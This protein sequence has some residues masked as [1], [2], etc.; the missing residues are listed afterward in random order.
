[1]LNVLQILFWHILMSDHHLYPQF[2]QCIV[3]PI[4]LLANPNKPVLTKRF[5]PDIFSMLVLP[6]VGHLRIT[7]RSQ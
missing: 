1:M 3:L 6:Q 5:I 7:L 4:L 2:L